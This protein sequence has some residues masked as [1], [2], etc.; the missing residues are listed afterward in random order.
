M[1]PGDGDGGLGPTRS[2]RP[3][4]QWQA[5]SRS[6]SDVSSPIA[7]PSR[8]AFLACSG[9]SCTACLGRLSYVQFGEPVVAVTSAGILRIPA[10]RPLRAGCFFSAARRIAST[11][12]LAGGETS[13]FALRGIA[14]AESGLSVYGHFSGYGHR[15][16]RGIRSIFDL[17]PRRKAT[18]AN[19]AA[20]HARSKSVM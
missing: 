12:N 11:T 19:R 8:N 9:G 4:D 7:K 17:R 14:A 5:W 15:F 10:R 6:L 3:G 2:F 18:A 16:L 1:P 13:V 20:W